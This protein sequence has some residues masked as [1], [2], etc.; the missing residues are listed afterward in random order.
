MVIG[1]IIYSV[2]VFLIFIGLFLGCYFKGKGQ[3]DD[4]L[5]A[6][7]KAEYSLKDF[8]PMGFQFDEMQVP[9]RLLPGELRELW[10]KHENKIFKKCLELRGSKYVNFYFLVHKS[11]RYT[12]AILAAS[13]FSLLG[14][15]MAMQK[16]LEN[17]VIFTTFALAAF[18]GA[19]LLVDSTLDKSIEKRRSEIRL[20]FPEFV[21]K[22]T[23]LVDAGMTIS[24]AWRKIVED[25]QKESVLYDEMN[26][27]LAE[28]RAGQPE[29]AAYEEFARRCKVKEVTKFV[30]IIIINLKRG[31]GEVVA[32][33]K[34]QGDECWEMRKAEV[35][36]LGEESSTKILIP[37]MFMFVGIIILVAMP[38]V[39]S[40]S[41]GM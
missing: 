33:L 18:P 36:R 9:E 14:F 11:Y 19:I 8:F 30:S 39:M 31:G 23:I 2:V 22:L 17:S 35:K 21:S 20:E 34:A 13:L 37:L 12:V 38:A 10:K 16:D 5:D 7:D 32:S 28:I 29:A 25:N 26:I 15:I 4:Y 24:Q 41:A 1:K 27:A 3:Y 40:F 6:L